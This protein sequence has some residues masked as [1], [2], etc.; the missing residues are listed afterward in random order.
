[1]AQ[2]GVEAIQTQGEDENYVQDLRA[3]CMQAGLNMD[4]SNDAEQMQHLLWQ[5]AE[6]NH[7]G[8]AALKARAKE[9]GAPVDDLSQPSQGLHPWASAQCGQQLNSE[10]LA[11]LRNKCYKRND[12]RN[13]PPEYADMLSAERNYIMCRLKA[14]M[15][16]NA[17]PKQKLQEECKRRQ[18][19]TIDNDSW[20]A[21]RGKGSEKADLISRLQ[22][23]AFPKGHV[24]WAPSYNECAWTGSAWS[25]EEPSQPKQEEKPAEQDQQVFQQVA[26]AQPAAHQRLGLVV[27]PP[28]KSDGPP[29][30][31]PRALA[32]A[33]PVAA[34]AAMD[35]EKAAGGALYQDALIAVAC[36]AELED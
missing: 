16:W 1:M 23:D 4:W 9:I 34:V 18:I 28:K 30:P 2:A 29:Q 33:T 17:M 26:Q 12:V 5:V 3:T 13:P 32:P 24:G 31:F 21:G 25:A 6:L 8:I 11:E 35:I 20:W 10:E 36:L 15:I 7:Y 19:P 14:S 22:Q 27:A